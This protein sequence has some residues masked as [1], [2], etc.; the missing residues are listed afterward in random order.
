MV[1]HIALHF[2][3]LSL[4][5]IRSLLGHSITID[6]C[7]FMQSDSTNF[8]DEESARENSSLCASFLQKSFPNIYTCNSISYPVQVMQILPAQVD[9]YVYREHE[10]GRRADWGFPHGFRMKR[11]KVFFISYRS[12]VY[13]CCVPL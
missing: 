8:Y 10:K 12:Y 11:L 5:C 2:L 6:G 1:I 4:S 7:D 13:C 3:V 9:D